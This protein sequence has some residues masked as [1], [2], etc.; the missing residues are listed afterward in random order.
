MLLLVLLLKL[1]QVLLLV[2][3][4]LLMLTSLFAGPTLADPQGTKHNIFYQQHYQKSIGNTMFGGM[5]CTQFYDTP[6]G[7]KPYNPDYVECINI[8][9]PNTYSSIDPQVQN[10]LYLT[11]MYLTRISPASV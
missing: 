10:T 7:E 4:R 6:S 5:E 11:R 8:H 3:L 9:L 2:L 1:L